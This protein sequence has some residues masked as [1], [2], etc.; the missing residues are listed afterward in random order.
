MLDKNI[1]TFDEQSKANT[2]DLQ[3]CVF[4]L[5]GY[6]VSY[7]NVSPVINSVL[8][9]VKM[10]PNKLPCKTTINNVN[11]ERLALS[12]KH[13]AEELGPKENLCLLSDETN[14]FGT[15]I[16]G[17]HVTDSSGNYWVL[18]LREMTTKAGKDILK[19]L[20]NIMGDIDATSRTSENPVSRTIL[21]N[22][23]S[24]M[25]DRA[26]TQTKF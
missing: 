16:E 17:M 23:S 1:V 4:E 12:Q 3:K 15:K 8:Q 9:L 7:Q 11:I 24:I 14:K 5:L 6:N 25:S 20:L 13:I 26:S 2:T 21:K 22:I 18:G 19:S 10:K